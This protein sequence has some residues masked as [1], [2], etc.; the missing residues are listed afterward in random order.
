MKENYFGMKEK[1]FMTK[2]TAG[3]GEGARLLHTAICY[4]FL[5]VPQCKKTIGVTD[6]IWSKIW[7]IVT[8]GS[9]PR[10]LLKM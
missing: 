9:I 6:W 3:S 4:I 2:L 7:T 1:G 5:S 8:A 10:H